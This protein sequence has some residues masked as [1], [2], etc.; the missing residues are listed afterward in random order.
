MCYKSQ[1]VWLLT[2]LRLKCPLRTSFVVSV[3]LSSDKRY[4]EHVMNT[5]IAICNSYF[6]Q[7]CASMSL[8]HTNHYFSCVTKL[9]KGT[10]QI[11]RYCL[12]VTLKAGFSKAVMR[13]LLSWNTA[14]GLLNSSEVSLRLMPHEDLTLTVNT[15]FL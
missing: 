4:D 2:L 8:L 15:T 7:F 3:Q 11:I 14:F 13:S 5:S 9:N 10:T 12:G 1:Y 6:S